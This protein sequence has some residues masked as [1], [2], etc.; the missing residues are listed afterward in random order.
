MPEICNFHIC[1]GI[2]KIGQCQNKDIENLLSFIYM[3]FDILFTSL[4]EYI[5]MHRELLF[6]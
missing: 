6:G 2:Y 4:Q 1:C 5:R 3:F